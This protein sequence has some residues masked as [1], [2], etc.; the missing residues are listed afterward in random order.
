MDIE[1]CIK[2][3]LSIVMLTAYVFVQ[4]QVTKVE[5]VFTKSN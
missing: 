1:K 2:R 5:D 3:R 4:H